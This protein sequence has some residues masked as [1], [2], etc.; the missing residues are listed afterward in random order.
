MCRTQPGHLCFLP[1]S[2]GSSSAVAPRES[3][4]LCEGSRKPTFITTNNHASSAQTPTLHSLTTVTN[5]LNTIPKSYCCLQLLHAKVLLHF[6][7]PS[8]AA[9]I[10][11]ERGNYLVR[12]SFTNESVRMSKVE[13]RNFINGDTA[14]KS[15]QHKR[16]PM[17]VFL[18]LTVYSHTQINQRERKKTHSTHIIIIYGV[19]READVL[20]V[21]P[22][23]RKHLP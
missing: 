21:S 5:R 11:H 16:S 14:W 17:C 10:C 6:F 8:G 23:L 13:S 20:N 7:F 3:R 1:L 2:P 4:E 18:K 9:I 19:W 15:S 22:K 12:F